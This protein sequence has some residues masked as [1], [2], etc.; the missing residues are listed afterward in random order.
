MR[1]GDLASHVLPVETVTA[2]GARL[3]PRLLDLLEK[4]TRLPEQLAELPAFRNSLAGEET[5]LESVLVTARST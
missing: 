2:I 5:M 4:I 3:N 1:R